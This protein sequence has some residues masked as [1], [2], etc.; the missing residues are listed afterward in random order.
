MVAVEHILNNITLSGNDSGR[1]V[2]EGT[3]G[4]NID[5]ER[6]L[7]GKKIAYI[8]KERSFMSETTPRHPPTLNTRIWN[9]RR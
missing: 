4:T 9:S 7:E 5:S 1:V 2:N 8:D 3:A 6:S